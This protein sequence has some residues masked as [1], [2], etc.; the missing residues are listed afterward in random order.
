MFAIYNTHRQ[1]KQ[2]TQQQDQSQIQQHDT[3]PMQVDLRLFF[4]T[5]SNNIENTTKI[6]IC[7]KIGY[8]NKENNLVNALRII[9]YDSNCTFDWAQQFRWKTLNILQLN[10]GILF[11]LS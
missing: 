2:H 9:F 6:G 10:L 1:H 5:Y 3:T 4:F 11:I 7:N 8:T